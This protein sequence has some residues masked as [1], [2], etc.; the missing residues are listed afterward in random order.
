MIECC[1]VCYDK[2]GASSSVTGK[3][4]ASRSTPPCVLQVA[5]HV[6]VDLARVM[7]GPSLPLALLVAKTQKDVVETTAGWSEMGCG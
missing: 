3:Q 4:G 5:V 2:N 6:K 7:W 1:R